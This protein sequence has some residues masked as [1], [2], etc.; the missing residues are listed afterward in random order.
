[1]ATPM[2]ETDLAAR[3][4]AWLRDRGLTVY[5]EVKVAYGDCVADLVVDVNGRAWVIEVKRSLGLTV[6]RQAANWTRRVPRVSVAVPETAPQ[7]DGLRGPSADRRFAYQLCKDRGIGIIEVPAPTAS[8]LS[9]LSHLSADDAAAITHHCYE[10]P[11][12]EPVEPRFRR[13]PKHVHNALDDCTEAHQHFCPA[14]SARGGYITEYRSTMDRIEQFLC[15]HGPAT[16]RQIVG[17]VQHHWANDTTARSC[18]LKNIQTVEEPKGWIR[19][20]R[21]GKAWTFELTGKARE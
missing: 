10:Y 20:V 14:G 19:S 12:K 17:D 11:I 15:K 6:I 2:R 21:G 18:V 7:P 4:V 8:D 1:M 16:A 9:H 13:L 3:V 5:Q